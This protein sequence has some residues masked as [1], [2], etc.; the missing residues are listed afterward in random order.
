M[1]K[2][3]LICLTSLFLLACERADPLGINSAPKSRLYR[4]GEEKSWLG[5]HKDTIS[6]RGEEWH[7]VVSQ[8]SLFLEGA[9]L[10]INDQKLDTLNKLGLGTEFENEYIAIVARGNTMRVT[11]KENK[12]KQP[13]KFSFTVGTTESPMGRWNFSVVQDTLKNQ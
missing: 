9:S 12:T 10:F 2:F 5:Q 3:F 7:F 13:N 4:D 11:I 6:A 8:G 1:K